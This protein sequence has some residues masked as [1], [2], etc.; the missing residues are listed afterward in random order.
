MGTTQHHRNHMD[1]FTVERSF[2]NI[3]VLSKKDNTEEKYLM[4][5]YT[6]SSK[7]ELVEKL[8]FFK[9]YKLKM[10]ENQ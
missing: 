7:E 8:R 9:D 6:A 1:L 2:G 10:E 5:T 3:S 4:K